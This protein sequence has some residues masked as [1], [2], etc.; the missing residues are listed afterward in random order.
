MSDGDEHDPFRR[1]NVPRT[2]TA[3]QLAAAFATRYK[4]ARRGPAAE[5]QR[6]AL[7]QALE[8]LRD[9]EARAAAEVDGWLLPLADDRAVPE[10]PELLAV[11][12]PCRPD[13]PSEPADAVPGPAPSEVAQRLLDTLEAPEPPPVRELLRRLAARMAIEAYDPWS[14]G[15]E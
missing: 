11:L 5:A 7:N 6:Q 14:D 15:D 8:T 2:A 9:P 1:L 12:L 3:G 4:A 10:L 13:T